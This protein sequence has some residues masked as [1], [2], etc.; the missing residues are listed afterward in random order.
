MVGNKL[1][2]GGFMSTRFIIH[3]LAAWLL[4]TTA[5][6][7][8][9]RVH[10]FVAL[11]DNEHQGIAKVPVKIGNG[12]D[13]ANNLY[14]G[15]TDGFKSVFGRSKAWKLEKTEENPSPEIL[16]RRSYRHTSKDCVLVAEAWR[17]KNIHEC[18]EAFFANLHGRKSDLTAF[19][20]HNGLMDAPVAVSTA[21]ASAKST[22]AIV[23]CCISSR[24]FQ[25]HLEALKARP[26]LTTEQF[27]YPGSFLLRD[28]LDVWLRGGPQSEIR[29][30]AAKAYATNQNISVKAAA[31]VFT[32]IE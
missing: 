3:T 20:G 5:H 8:T 31:G 12:D 4:V 6:A 30:A 29:M 13:T 11:A 15:T 7:E 23:L 10:V 24:Y 26:V 2:T 1:E 18:L 9:K 32:R 21:D 25:S 27:M 19:I 28:A 14:W 22:D 17:G 16:E